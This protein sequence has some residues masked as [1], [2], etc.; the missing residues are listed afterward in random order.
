MTATTSMMPIATDS[1]SDSFMT[2]HGSMRE[3]ASR[4]RR[5]PPWAETVGIRPLAGRGF[6]RTGAGRGLAAGAVAG[7]AVIVGSSV[8]GRVKVA[9]AAVVATPAFLNHAVVASTATI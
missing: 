5:G 1:R 7:V 3:I 4:T 8:R 6:S 9:N 2:D